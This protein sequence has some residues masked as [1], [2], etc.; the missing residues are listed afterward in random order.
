MGKMNSKPTHYRCRVGIGISIPNGERGYWLGPG[1][2]LS[3]T[4]YA[5]LLEKKFILAEWFE[6]LA[7]EALETQGESESEI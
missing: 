6:E 7:T 5:E 1:S 2:F 3:R 4:E